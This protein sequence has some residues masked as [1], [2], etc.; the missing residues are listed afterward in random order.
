[1][2]KVTGLLALLAMTIVATGCA[3][4]A[5]FS[6]GMA[7]TG[8]WTRTHTWEEPHLTA[9]LESNPVKSEL[10]MGFVTVGSHAGLNDHPD[11]EWVSLDVSIGPK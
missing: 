3:A 7:N 5:G 8:V 2:K 10:G 9:D 11:G 1:M 4:S 6:A